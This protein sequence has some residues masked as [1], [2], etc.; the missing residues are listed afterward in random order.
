MCP[1]CLIGTG[2][3]D[4]ELVAYRT[5]NTFVVP[6]PDQ[7]PRNMGHCLILP[8][9]HVTSLDTAS[10]ELR[11]EIF[12]VVS[13]VV[14]AVP[15]AF[16]AVGSIVQQNN[17]IPGQVLHHLH[18]HV[19]PRFHGDDFSQPDPDKVKVPF[20]MRAQQAKRLRTALASR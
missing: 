5:S 12:E 2:E 19:I 10:T 4:A 9:E 16:N 7:R 20:E 11:N 18:V 8:T 14:A 3:A 13:R 6:V 15:K 17:S 1:F